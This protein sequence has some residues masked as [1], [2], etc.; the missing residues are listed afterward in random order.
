MS[1]HA[2]MAMMHTVDIVFAQRPIVTASAFAGV[3]IWKHLRVVRI[4][5]GSAVLARFG[6]T[7]VEI[8]FAFTARE[9][10]STNAGI[11]VHFIYTRPTIDARV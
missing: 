3:F 2:G 9:A 7:L 5:A 11:R 4:Q 10:R 6:S 8:G 1:R